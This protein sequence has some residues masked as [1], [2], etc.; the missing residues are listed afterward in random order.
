MLFFLILGCVRIW[1]VFKTAKTFTDSIY[2]YFCFHIEMAPNGKILVTM[3][4]DLVHKYRQRYMQLGLL[5]ERFFIWLSYWNK[6][7]AF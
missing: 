2:E 3:L 5:E 7:T 6:E 4:G 1:L